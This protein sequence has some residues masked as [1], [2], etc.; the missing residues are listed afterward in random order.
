VPAGA[1]VTQAETITVEP[2][3]GNGHREGWR[4]V[5]DEFAD[6]WMHHRR[7]RAPTS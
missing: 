2:G 7:P 6:W 5:L 1:V 4:G 3:N